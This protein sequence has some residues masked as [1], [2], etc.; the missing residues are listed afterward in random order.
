MLRHLS[1]HKRG[2]VMRE[3][4]LS[5]I[6]PVYNVAAYL[7]RSIQS[8]LNQTYQNLELILIN[9]G[10]TDNSGAICEKY[11]KRDP[12]VKL[13]TQKN[14][15]ASAARRRGLRLAAGAYVGFVDP[16]DYID[17]DFYQK[18]MECRGD[19]DV[20]IAQWWREPAEGP[21]RR[22]HDA[23]APGAY[24]T[25]EDMD[26]LIRHL[27]NVSLPGGS[28]NLQP[29]IA[30]YLWNKLFKAEL[31]K[32]AVE[33]IQADLP[34]SNDRPIIYQVMLKCRAV[35]VTEICGYH[36]WIREGSL[37]HDRDPDC[38]YLR[39]LCTFYTLM[40]GLFAQ[41]PRCDVLM[42]QLQLKLAEEITR[43]PAKM[44]F[45]AQAQLQVKTPVFPFLNLLD[46]RRIALYGAGAL[47][48]GYWRQIHRWH[49][50]Q[51]ALWT[52]PEWEEWSRAG[53]PVEPVERLLDGGY[54][55]VVLALPNQAAAEEARKL[56]TGMGIAPAR[57]LWRQPLE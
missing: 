44:G 34:V 47:G 31:L 24:T 6:V 7:D 3:N 5:I 2:M 12:R 25:P 45:A 21:A 18:L 20:V 32:A 49:V 38:R 46:G 43:A 33:E 8:I 53:L 29:G 23:I 37:G 40:T 13:V 15:G 11:A 1:A 9:D 19:F 42:P 26:F 28:V 39:N 54:D 10:S 35:L 51:T 30:A 22:A 27:I 55:D 14:Q 41:D 57:I 56:L 4:L 52:D 36:Y 17:E 16:D 50:C 48:R